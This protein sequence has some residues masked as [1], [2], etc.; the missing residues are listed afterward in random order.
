MAMLTDVERARR[1]GVVLGIPLG[2]LGWAQSLLMGA[3]AGFIAFFLSTFLSI[4]GFMIDQSVTGKT[5]DYSLT[6]KLIGIPVG[7]TVGVVSLAYLGVQWARRMARK[8]LG[9]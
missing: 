8:R 7:A 3:A 2:D 1:D 5:P 6:Y 9:A 4:V